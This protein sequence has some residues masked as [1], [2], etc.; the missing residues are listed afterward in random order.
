[1]L[2]HVPGVLTP[3][4]VAQI[5]QASDSAEWIDGRATVG[6]QGARVKRNR[7]LAEGGALSLR[8]GELILGAL[9]SHALFM[10]AALPL[11]YVPPLF[12]RYEGGEHYGLHIDG[13]VRGVPGTSLKLRTDLS[14]TLFF[15]APDDYDGGELEVVDTFG[16][17]EVKLPAGDLALYPSG[18]LHRVLPVTRDGARWRTGPWFLR[19]ERCY[20]IPGDSPVGYRLPLDSQPWVSKSDYPYIFDPDPMAPPPPLPRAADIRRQFFGGART[21][22][23]LALC[24]DSTRIGVGSE[25]TWRPVLDSPVRR[26]E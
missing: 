3:S 21:R 26:S 15:S 7:Q 22:R 25:Y 9:E 23:I 20:L 11:R 12:N 16:T 17:H 6:E 18:S 8:W 24:G 19:R 13:A 14:C 4:Q 1:M 10:S 2:L 5:R